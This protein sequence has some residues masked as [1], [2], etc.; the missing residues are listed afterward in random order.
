MSHS[1]IFDRLLRCWSIGRSTSRRSSPHTELLGQAEIFEERRLLSGIAIYPQPLAVQIE[2]APENFQSVPA[3]APVFPSLTGLWN[4]SASAEVDGESVG[5]FT[6]TI[7]ITQKKGKLTGVVQVQG[8]PTFTI[9]GKLDKDEVLELSGKSKFPVEVDA[10]QFRGVR[11]NVQI[12]FTQDLQSFT[13]QFD[14]TI[15]GH[16]IEGTI[17]GQRQHN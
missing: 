6:G 11:V 12:S 13:G 2:T 9:K 4:V 8:L 17:S 3:A 14:R 15:F 1:I 7:E 5:N 10:G 16:T